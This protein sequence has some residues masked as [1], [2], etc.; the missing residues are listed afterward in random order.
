MDAVLIF[1]T[2]AVGGGLAIVF[3][4]LGRS[5]AA[6]GRIAGAM[7][8]ITEDSPDLHHAEMSMPFSQRL[9]GPAFGVTQ[10]AVRAVTPSWWID[11]IRRNASLAGLG[12]LGVEGALALKAVAAVGGAILFV[13]GATVS[14]IGVGGGLMWAVVGGAVG[15]FVPDLLIARRAD[16]RQAQIRRSLPESLDLLAIAVQAGMGLEQAIELVAQRLSGALGEELQRMLQEVQLGAS[17]REALAHLRERTDVSELS[18]FVLSLAQADALGSPLGEVLRVQA[19]EMRMLRRQRAREM[20]AKVPVKLLFP[21]L[22]FIF[23]ALAIVVIG[24]AI[25]S[26]LNAFG[27]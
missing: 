19:Q 13:L 1:G 21:L 5:V 18:T 3:L 6:A 16:A 15:F 7:E 20:A 10:R 26:I 9:L 14:G 8:S 24:P 4:G 2:L 17:R 23:P 22:A 25:V 27:G 11:R 12:R